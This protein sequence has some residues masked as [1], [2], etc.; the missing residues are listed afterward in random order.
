MFDGGERVVEVKSARQRD[1]RHRN[2]IG[3]LEQE[4]IFGL[5]SEL[6]PITKNQ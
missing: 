5:H 6:Y 3:G 1:D 4:L 2:V